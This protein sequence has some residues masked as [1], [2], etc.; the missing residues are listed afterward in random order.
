MKR[1]AYKIVSACFGLLGMGCGTQP[2]EYGPPPL[3]EYELDGKVINAESQEP[4]E[5]LE[6]RF[7]DV[8][9]DTDSAGSWSIAAYGSACVPN[10]SLD[11]RDVDG[12]N[13]GAFK[14]RRIGLEL[15]KT[16]AAQGDHLGVFE[17]H[18]LEISL[19]PDSDGE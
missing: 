19:D 17:Q 5:N 2:V 7:M 14:N 15:V 3:A 12:E 18:D 6:V 4:I 1:A 9:A 16:Q 13:H 10:C 8:S 11:V